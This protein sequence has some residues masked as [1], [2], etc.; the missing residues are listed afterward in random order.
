MK[1][2]AGG[3]VVLKLVCDGFKHMHVQVAV[4]SGSA[5]IINQDGGENEAKIHTKKRSCIHG[6]Q[7]ALTR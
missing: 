4:G 3:K 5:G 2:W 1:N 7:I 6:S